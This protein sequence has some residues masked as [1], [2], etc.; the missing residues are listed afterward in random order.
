MLCALVICST[1]STGLY[2][3]TGIVQTGSF[4]NGLH[5]LMKI[6]YSEQVDLVAV[7]LQYKFRDWFGNKNMPSCAVCF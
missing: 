1:H 5:Y 6:T 3:C 2:G 7:F 4:V